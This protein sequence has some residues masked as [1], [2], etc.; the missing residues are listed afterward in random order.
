MRGGR[1]SLPYAFIEQ[2]IYMFMTVLR[3]PLATEQSRKLINIF[4]A[5]SKIYIFC[6]KRKSNNKT[7]F[8]KFYYFLESIYIRRTF[9]W[10]KSLLL[11]TVSS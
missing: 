9:L 6:D 2:G 4:N 11:K 7:F 1:T 10:K 5:E 8:S 3:C